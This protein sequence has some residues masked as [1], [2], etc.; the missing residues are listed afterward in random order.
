MMEIDLTQI[1]TYGYRVFTIQ[2][3][4]YEQK[5]LLDLRFRIQGLFEIN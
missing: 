2:C 1:Y 5:Q 4:N 3:W